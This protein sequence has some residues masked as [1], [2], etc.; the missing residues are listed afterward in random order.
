[1]PNI[2]GNHRKPW[3]MDFPKKATEAD[4]VSCFRL[5]LG[6][7]PG[8]QEWGGHSWKVGEELGSVVT[9]YLN[10]QEF[11]RRRL[12]DT[13]VGQWQLVSMPTFKMY[14]SAEDKS[15]GKTIIYKR[16]YER[17]VTQMFKEHLRPGMGVLDLG[18][19]IGYFSLL[20]ASLVGPAGFVQSWEP[21]PLNV[22]A[23]C[24]SRAVNGFENIE[25]VQAAAAEKNGLLQYFRNSINGSVAGV[26]HTSPDDLFTA[27]TVMGLRVDDFISPNTQV[28]FIKIDVEGYEFK[29]LLGARKTIERCRPV[30]VSEFAPP[31]LEDSSGVSGREYL[32][33]LVS[34]GYEVLSIT[35]FRMKPGSVDEIL[36]RFEQSRKDHID[37]VL[38]PR[39]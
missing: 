4:V 9:S 21:A 36:T 26:E 24:A 31:N 11:A 20:A 28:G 30:I 18:A 6:R 7:K 39:T 32:E 38:L 33:F 2:F 1:M 17:P 8:Q 10:S 12:L 27:E 15:I 37:I 29:A 22:R 3:N 34:L 23:L 14:A 13:G 16:A 19:N 35:R 5:L 25:V